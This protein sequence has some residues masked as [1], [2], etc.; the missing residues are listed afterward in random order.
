[1][2][3]K[4]VGARG[5]L[6]EVDELQIC[7]TSLTLSVTLWWPV[8]PLVSCALHLPS[9]ELVGVPEVPDFDLHAD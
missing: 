8:S 4:F 3:Q 7:L 6:R 9:R 5:A 1:M 2:G